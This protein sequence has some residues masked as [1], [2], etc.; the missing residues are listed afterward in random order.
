[1]DY[2]YEITA[3]ARNYNEQSIRQ[4]IDYAERRLQEIIEN[5]KQFIAACWEQWK[6]IENTPFKQY[7]YLK[8]RQHYSTKRIE[9]YTGVFKCPDIENGE[10]YGYTVMSRRFTGME[11]KGAREYAERLAAQYG[12]EIREEGF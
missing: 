4:S 10:S 12:C 6:K 1:M 2:H 8:R 9:F 7:V 11:Y 3:V 5:H